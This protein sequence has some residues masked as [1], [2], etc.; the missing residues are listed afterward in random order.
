MTPLE[1][2]RA[3][4]IQQVEAL[5]RQLD[6]LPADAALVLDASAVEVV[7]SLGIQ[8]LLALDKRQR[9]AGGSLVLRG[10]TIRFREALADL[11]LA[12]A[13]HADTDPADA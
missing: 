13:L 7:D 10:M 9:Q 5:M 4:T 11:G 8:L 2:P 3:L 1:L 6:S 12:E